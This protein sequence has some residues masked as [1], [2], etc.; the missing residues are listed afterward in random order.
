M[1]LEGVADDVGA[2]QLDAGPLR[3][4]PEFGAVIGMVEGLRHARERRFGVR[5]RRGAEAAGGG[6]G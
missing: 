2:V 6:M 5:V 1:R 4:A 3:Q